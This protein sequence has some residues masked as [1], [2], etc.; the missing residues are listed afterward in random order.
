[1]GDEANCWNLRVANGELRA[2]VVCNQSP[3][4]AAYIVPASPC[5]V[6][7]PMSLT[8]CTVFLYRSTCRAWYFPTTVHTG[9]RVLIGDRY[10]W[11]VRVETKRVRYVYLYICDIGSIDKR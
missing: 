7:R 2:S 3:W 5:L 11:S 9:L 4:C 8:V 10:E 6:G 1:M